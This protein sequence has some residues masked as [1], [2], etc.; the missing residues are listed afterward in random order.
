MK[1]VSGVWRRCAPFLLAASCAF[2]PLQ[3][4]DGPS[5]DDADSTESQ[6]APSPAD[7]ALP[8]DALADAPA[9]TPVSLD[10]LLPPDVLPADASAPPDACV[11]DCTAGARRC[12]AGGG[13]QT[14]VTTNG[15]TAWSAE[16]ACMAPMT[17]QGSGAGAA[18]A[19]PAPPAGCA[20]GQ[21][22]F[23]ES[24]TVVAT[25]TA[26]A[27]GCLKIASRVTCPASKPCAGKHPSASCS[28]AAPPPEC[29]AG[30]GASCQGNML[31]T[32]AVDAAGCIAVSTQMACPAGRPC[33]GAAPNGAC[34]CPA[35]PAGCNGTQDRFCESST[36]VA[37]C[38]V[39]SNGCLGV[40]SR[41][42][43]PAGK[44][45][46]GSSNAACTC[47]PAPAGCAGQAGTFCE[48]ASSVATC[49]SGSNGCLDIV[50]RSSCPAGKS[51]SG[52]A[53]AAQ[54][55]CPAGPSDCSGPGSVCRANNT[56]ATC[57]FDANGCLT[58]TASGSCS[59]GKTCTGGFPNAACACPPG[60]SDCGGAGKVCRGST[61]A[62]CGF[63]G[64]GCLGTTGTITC[65]S[66]CTGS[67]PG[68]ACASPPADASPP[69]PDAPACGTTCA[70]NTGSCC[71]STVDCA[72]RSDFCK[73]PSG[74]IC[75]G[76]ANCTCQTGCITSGNKCLNPEDC[77]PGSVCGGFGTCVAGCKATNTMRC[78]VDADCCSGHC[79]A[80]GGLP[81]CLK[82]CQ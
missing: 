73:Q 56:L 13:L 50:G 63:D 70:S 69:P 64:N 79:A 12:G 2:H 40:S 71:K 21:G 51:C 52:S 58:T 17:C 20:S 9:D 68:A 30:V 14:C 76:Q 66:G 80:G 31:V 5:E 32:C 72:S 57:G 67:F 22:S 35:P 11:S 18:C 36:T 33:M 78:A 23:C 24:S 75:N 39:A 65:A 77:C 4:T 49:A 62:T 74:E 59:S 47:L 28:C 6:D 19:C 41:S 55:T 46:M 43:C 15:C 37:Q 26:D 54:C 42:T 27:L 38:G 29:A 25:C 10:S 8:G 44:P 45:C 34:T 81:A 1:P 7:G 3:D 16:V 61:L 53:P 60:P 48:S 82:L